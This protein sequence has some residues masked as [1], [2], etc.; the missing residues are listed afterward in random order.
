M[1]LQVLIPASL[2]NI[3]DMMQFWHHFDVRQSPFL[4]KGLCQHSVYSPFLEQAY[5]PSE[6]PGDF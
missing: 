3:A 6:F 1:N 5:N 2:P 4:L